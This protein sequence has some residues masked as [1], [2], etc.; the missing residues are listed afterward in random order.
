MAGGVRQG[1]RP[2]RVHE[3]PQQVIR[4]KWPG[5]QLEDHCLNAEP[6]T[7]TY[8]GCSSFFAWQAPT[9]SMIRSIVHVGAR[10][11]SPRASASRGPRAYKSRPYMDNFNQCKK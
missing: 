6:T 4:A 9:T 8:G 2:R 11:I 5:E 3:R 1:L 10:F 7:D